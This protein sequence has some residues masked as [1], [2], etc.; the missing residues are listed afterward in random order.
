MKE[1]KVIYSALEP[2]VRVKC[3]SHDSDPI[4]SLALIPFQRL[5]CQ[6]RIDA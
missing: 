3:Q 6:F 5:A 2:G 1:R 4:P